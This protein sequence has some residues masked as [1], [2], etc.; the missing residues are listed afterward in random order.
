LEGLWFGKFEDRCFTTL[1]DATLD[2]PL[3]DLLDLIQGDMLNSKASEIL[4]DT[5]KFQSNSS[6]LLTPDQHPLF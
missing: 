2:R 1:G 4:C 3:K 6:Y 5:L